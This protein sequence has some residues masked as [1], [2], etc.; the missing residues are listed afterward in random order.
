MKNRKISTI[1]YMQFLSRF[2]ERTLI[3]TYGFYICRLPTSFTDDLQNFDFK[4]IKKGFPEIGFKLRTTIGND[5][6]WE[7]MQS[8]NMFHELK[9]WYFHYTGWSSLFFSIQKCKSP[10]IFTCKILLEIDISVSIKFDLKSSA[11]NSFLF[12]FS[13]YISW[14]RLWRTSGYFAVFYLLLFGLKWLIKSLNLN[15]T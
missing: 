1:T 12:I 8:I 7:T 11:Y 15:V 10:T 13:L 5:L 14:D 9:S 2:L 6:I 4:T 3:F